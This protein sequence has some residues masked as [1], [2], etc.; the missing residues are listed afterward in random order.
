MV[1]GRLVLGLQ[2]PIQC[3]RFV[4]YVENILL[5]KSSKYF[6]LNCDFFGGGYWNM[7]LDELHKN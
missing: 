7:K 4:T 5:A 2:E 1:P 6:G 3:L